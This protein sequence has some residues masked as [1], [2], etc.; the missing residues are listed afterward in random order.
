MNAA[1]I[2]I[3]KIIQ[4]QKGF[5]SSNS[6]SIHCVQY[7]YSPHASMWLWWHRLST[8]FTIKTFLN[9]HFYRGKPQREQRL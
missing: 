8:H 3:F 7:V 9:S 2:Y 6:R 4:Q 5:T 1:P